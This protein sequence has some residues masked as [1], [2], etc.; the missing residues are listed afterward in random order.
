MGWL[1][2]GAFNEVLS[3]NK[4]LGGNNVNNGCIKDFWNCIRNCSLIDL[5]YQATKFTWTNK[6]YIH[7]SQ[8]IFE[9]LDRY[10]ANDSC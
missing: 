2:G 6:K 5:D 1:L 7:H 4:K 9:R 3:A 8:L 10:L